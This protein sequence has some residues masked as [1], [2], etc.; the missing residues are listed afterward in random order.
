MTS[1]WTAE[2]ES[3]H[4]RAVE[5]NMMLALVGEVEGLANITEKQWRG[6]NRAMP[7]S[8][9]EIRKKLAD[10]RIYLHLLATS[11]GIDLDEA[12]EEKLPM[13]REKFK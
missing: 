8:D 3:I 4:R 11:L 12:I 1:D 5:K 2:L 13:I 9:P 6:D 7:E 10:I